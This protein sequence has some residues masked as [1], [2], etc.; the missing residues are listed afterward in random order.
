MFY[1]LYTSGSTSNVGW[2]SAKPLD[3]LI[4]EIVPSLSMIEGSAEIGIEGG[5]VSEYRNW[6]VRSH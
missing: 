4:G 6:L 2:L 5:Q 1:A 3:K